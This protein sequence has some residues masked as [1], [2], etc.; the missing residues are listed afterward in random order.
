MDKHIFAAFIALDE[1]KAF[2]AVEKFDDAI[3]FADDLCGHIATR[4]AATAASEAAATTAATATEAAAI[5]ATAAAK[6]ATV[7]ATE[8]ATA[9]AAASEAAAITAAVTAF[10][11]E[12]VETIFAET[13]ALVAPTPT[14]PTT[15]AV[16]S[17]ETHALNVTFA[18]S[19]KL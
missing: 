8:S 3:A 7:A 4:T 11:V 14:A 12:W 5:T 9:T 15:A 1:A 16:I 2:L 19:L 6:A 18:S 10:L 13:I 17:V